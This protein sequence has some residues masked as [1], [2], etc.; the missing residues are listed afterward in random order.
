MSQPGR[1][2]WWLRSLPWLPVSLA[3]R[4]A[5]SF[6]RASLWASER[7]LCLALHFAGRGERD[8]LLAELPPD[9]RERVARRC[10]EGTRAEPGTAADTAAQ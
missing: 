6:L 2:W 5:L 4:L 10:G 1:I 8:R 3:A 9:V 7:M